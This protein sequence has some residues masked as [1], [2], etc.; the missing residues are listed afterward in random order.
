ME[1]TLEKQTLEE[2]EKL[3]RREGKGNERRE[4]A[5]RRAKGEIV[6][7]T[8]EQAMVKEEQHGGK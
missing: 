4:Y 8:R 2:S 6:S 3:K 5:E 7:R 1:A